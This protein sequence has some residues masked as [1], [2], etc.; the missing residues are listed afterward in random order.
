M[1]TRNEHGLDE[2]GLLEGEKELWRNSQ[3][4]ITTSHLEEIPG[5]SGYWISLSVLK[6]GGWLQHMA[7][8]K[9]VDQ[10]LFREAFDKVA[11][12]TP[13][14]PNYGEGHL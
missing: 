11:E 14:K 7:K 12:L 9:W 4:R 2:N 8:K 5:G 10:D 6:R 13:F 1:G 3:W